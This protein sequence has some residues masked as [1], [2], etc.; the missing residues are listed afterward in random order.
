LLQDDLPTQI[1]RVK[2]GYATLDVPAA[3]VNK[4]LLHAPTI[5]LT[6]DLAGDS[7]ERPLDLTGQLPGDTWE[8]PLVIDNELP[9]K[10]RKQ[11]LREAKKRR[12]KGRKVQKVAKKASV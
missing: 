5:D 12:V 2:T 11:C 8:R 7:A 10:K 3:T 1:F 6:V 4:P 9:S